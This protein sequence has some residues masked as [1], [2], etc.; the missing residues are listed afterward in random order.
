MASKPQY[1]PKASPVTPIMPVKRNSHTMMNTLERIERKQES[2]EVEF[3]AHAQRDEDSF[4]TIHK[5]FVAMR[6]LIADSMLKID[7][8]VKGIEDKIETQGDKLQAQ[9][10][11]LKASKLMQEG[12]DRGIA[13]AKQPNPYLIAIVPVIVTFL[14]TF[15]GAWWAHDYLQPPPNEHVTTLTTLQTGEGKHR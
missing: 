1:N 9:I 2:M 15:I 8:R 10:D 6:Q 14:I 5:S 7:A 4:D 12:Y 13:F 3:K 11:P